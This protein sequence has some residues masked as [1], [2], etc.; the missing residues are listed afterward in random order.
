MRGKSYSEVLDVTADHFGAAHVRWAKRLAENRLG[1]AD[2][3]L[4]EGT[5]LK[6]A[7]VDAE[8]AKILAVRN[9]PKPSKNII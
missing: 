8:T 9:Y 1:G 2:G 7:D 5:H 6:A 3:V 4:D